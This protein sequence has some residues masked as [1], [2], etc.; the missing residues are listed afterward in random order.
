MSEGD[1]GPPIPPDVL[2][3]LRR[4][5]PLRMTAQG[6]LVLG[7]ED[8]THPRVIAALRAGLDVTEAGEPTVSLGPHWIYLTVD[9]CPLRA[10]AVR[11]AGD[12]TLWMRLDDGRAVPLDPASL[13]EEPG[14]GL[15][16]R[17]A[18]QPSGRALA[19]RF[20]NPALMDLAEH[21]DDDGV[22]IVGGVCYEIGS[23]DPATSSA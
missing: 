4:S 16:S 18:S 9:D 20:T 19:V 12:G 6:R 8:V 13:W 3:R 17:A 23:S 2:D 1:A 10:L 11:S 22:L 7:G 15:R 14:R 21:L 5:V